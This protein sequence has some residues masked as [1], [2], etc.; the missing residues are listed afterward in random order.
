[1]R[2]QSRDRIRRIGIVMAYA[3]NDPNGQTQ[4]SAL[5]DELQKLGWIEGGNIQI[6]VRYAKDNPTSVRDLAREL[7]A[8]RPDVMV[9]NS[10]LVTSILQTSVGDVPLV[11]ISVSDPVGSGFIK[12]LARPGGGVT[13]FANFQPSMGSKWLEKL[14]EIAPQLDRV[15]LMYHPEP[16]NIGYLKSAQSVAPQLNVKLVELSVHNSAEIEGAFSAF[17]EQANSGLIVV[18]NVVAFANSELIVGLAERHHLPAIYPFAFFAR[19]G[20][21]ISY[22]F[23]E[24]DQFRQGAVYIDKILKGAKPADLPVQ[25]PTKFEITINLRTAKA[26]DINVPTQ[27]LQL[28]DQVIE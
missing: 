24:S 17:G 5:R 22:G 14:R 4:V 2:G 20:G 18:P 23:D 27:L 28:A 26:L 6:D 3:A 10:N 1:V 8:Q 25:Y 13:G 9:S 19:E 15:G 12:E 16:P 21:L 11:F 7:L